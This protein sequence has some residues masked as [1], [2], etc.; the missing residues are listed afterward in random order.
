MPSMQQP[1]AYVSGAAGL[2]GED[3]ELTNAARRTFFTSLM[4]WIETVS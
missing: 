2:F 4:T 1:E 3:G